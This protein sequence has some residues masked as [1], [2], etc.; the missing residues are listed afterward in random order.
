MDNVPIT[1]IKDQPKAK[2]KL[3]RNLTVYEEAA[4]ID[5]AQM[6]E[7]MGRQV[8]STTDRIAEAVEDIEESIIA[9]TKRLK[10]LETGNMKP[11]RDIVIAPK[12]LQDG[13]RH[14]KNI[15][16][17]S[18]GYM[19]LEGKRG[20][21]LEVE[22]SYGKKIKF[23]EDSGPFVFEL[24]DDGYIIENGYSNNRAYFAD[25]ADLTPAEALKKFRR[26]IPMTKKQY[27]QLLDMAKG[28]AFTVAGIVE[29]DILKSV[30][31][32]LYKAIREGAPLKDFAFALKQANIK[33][34]G[35]VYGSDAKKGEPISPIHTETI[36][37]TNFASVFNDGRWDLFNDPAVVGFVPAYQYSGILDN[38]IRETHRKMDGKI[39]PRDDPIWNRWRPPC[40]YNCRCILTPVTINMKYSV[41]NPTA[42]KPDPGF[43]ALTDTRVA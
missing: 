9:Q 11:I 14:I 41:S 3:W 35:T 32:M 37:R 43:G 12:K 16:L 42:L 29:K 39:Y 21:L 13:V 33:Y 2:P 38:R 7:D 4:K 34:T 27:S 15:C 18:F 8:K 40:G 17:N 31:E 19:Y 20:G 6:G 1:A 30:Q 22:N 10:I 36:V 25:I 23:A 26:K 5:F 28:R 24:K